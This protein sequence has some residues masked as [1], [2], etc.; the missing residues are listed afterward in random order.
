MA[1]GKT[2]TREDERKIMTLTEMGMKPAQIAA[3]LGLGKTTVYGVAN[4]TREENNQRLRQRRAA[5][6][7][8]DTAAQAVYRP[9]EAVQMAI[10]TPAAPRQLPGDPAHI[11]VGQAVR[12]A[13]LDA[14]Q[15]LIRAEKQKAWRLVYAAM[16]QAIRDSRAPA[17]GAEDGDSLAAGI[18]AEE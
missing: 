1:R 13:I 12:Q 10:E 18:M 8:E 4:G 9:E 6:R 7:P 3:F 15:E 16:L 5:A 17:G 11:L 14:A 2:I